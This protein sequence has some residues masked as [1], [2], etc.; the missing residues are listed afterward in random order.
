ML[1]PGV[2]G[3]HRPKRGQKGFKLKKDPWKARIAQTVGQAEGL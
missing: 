1:K 3:G 2:L